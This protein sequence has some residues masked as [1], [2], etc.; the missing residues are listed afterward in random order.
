MKLLTKEIIKK[1][2]PIYFND[3]KPK[4][5]QKIIVKFFDAFG[6]WTWYVLEGR[7]IEEDPGNFEFYGF[8]R[9]FENELGYFT[10]KELERLTFKG[11]PRIERDM[12]F[13]DHFLNEA[14]ESNI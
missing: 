8:V 2:L 4:E 1:L 11:C 14:M 5:K 12:Y 3:G 7:K 13:G 6:G 10:L 9:G